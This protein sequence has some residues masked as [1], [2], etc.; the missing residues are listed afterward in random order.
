MKIGNKHI[1]KEDIYILEKGVD[2]ELFK[3]FTQICNNLSKQS[4]QQK[5]P[6]EDECRDLLLDSA[7]PFSRKKELLALLSMREKIKVLRLLESLSNHT[8]IEQELKPWVY[9]ATHCC[10]VGIENSLGGDGE[11]QKFYIITGLGGSGQKLRFCIFFFKKKGVNLQEFQTEILKK[12]T[13]FELEKVGGELESFFYNDPYFI[14]N[15]LIPIGLSY[16]GIFKRIRTSTSL[17]GDFLESNIWATNAKKL[18]PEE[19]DEILSKIRKEGKEALGENSPETL[20]L[21]KIEGDGLLSDED[22]EN[23]SIFEEDFDFP[24]KDENPSDEEE[25]SEEE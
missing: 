6:S 21:K 14:V 19:I 3:D 12:E 4:T 24:E 1:P 15:C 13:K 5:Q 23:Y 11:T 2:I 20:N 18:S 16:G 8:E 10:R 17:Y 9:F 7:V 22:F 25:D